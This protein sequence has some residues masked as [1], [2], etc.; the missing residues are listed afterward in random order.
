M[1]GSKRSSMAS[2]G[3]GGSKEVSAADGFNDNKQIGSKAY[4][5]R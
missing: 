2:S 1:V 5:D 3:G 4:V